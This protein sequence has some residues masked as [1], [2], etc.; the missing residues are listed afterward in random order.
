MR[1][2]SEPVPQHSPVRALSFVG[3]GAVVT[4]Y[5]IG[6][7]PSRH[8]LLLERETRTNARLAGVR[9]PVAA[10]D[11]E[12][13]GAREKTTRINKVTQLRRSPLLWLGTAGTKERSEE[14]P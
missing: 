6:R 14:A 13:E 11:R 4:W 1:L 5:D 12:G 2:R 7:V 8:G 10:G 9:S 3:S